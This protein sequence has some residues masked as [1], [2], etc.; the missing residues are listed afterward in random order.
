[1]NLSPSSRII[2]PD[3]VV[4]R[5]VAGEAVILNLNSEQY[6]SLDEVGTRMWL[7]L[8]QH[9]TVEAAVDELLAEYDVE[10][11]RLERDLI[12]LIEKLAEHSLVEIR[13]E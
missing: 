7:M 3:D 8:E 2:V 5:E 4:M 9:E 6:F 10:R 13:D 1:M 11:A 12:E